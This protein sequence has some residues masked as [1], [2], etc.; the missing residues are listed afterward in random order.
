[1]KGFVLFLVIVLLAYTYAAPADNYGEVKASDGSIGSG[2]ISDSRFGD[3]A[4]SSSG[5]GK[6][7][8]VVQRLISRV[9]DL[10]C[11]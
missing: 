2:A 4:F 5:R 3:G 11:T 1:M 10:N 6:K 8:G 9:W 7:C